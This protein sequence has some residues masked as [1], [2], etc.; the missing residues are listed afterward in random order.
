MADIVTKALEGLGVAGAIITVLMTTIGA[1]CSVI[2]AQWKHSNKV[3]GYRLQERDTLNKALS[4][5]SRV[6]A[7]LVRVSDE[8]N[9]LTEEQAE[10]LSEQATALELLRNTVLNQYEVIRDHQQASVQAVASIAEALR[11]LHGL[12]LEHKLQ[13]GQLTNEVRL[14][15]GESIQTIIKSNQSL[16]TTMRK[17]IGT[18]VTIVSRKKGPS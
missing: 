5:S 15:I 2:V 4:D 9:E 6:L 7:D 10:L 16:V 3:Y 14:L 8:R 1:L 12:T 13:G 17:I 11:A 18:E